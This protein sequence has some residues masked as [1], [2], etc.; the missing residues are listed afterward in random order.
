MTFT[1]LTRAQ[2]A[3]HA[4]VSVHTI[5]RWRKK[6]LPW[7]KPGG[8]ILIRSD[9]LDRFIEL[10]VVLMLVV[11]TIS[12]LLY[13]FMSSGARGDTSEDADH[14]AASHRA[15]EQ[16]IESQRPDLARSRSSSLSRYCVTSM[17]SSSNNC[18]PSSSRGS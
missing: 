7:R 1:W 15:N 3:D 18:R 8:V 9:L 17:P 5:D 12:V 6:G 13:A 10:S 16:R 4:S 11:F 2:A 14:P